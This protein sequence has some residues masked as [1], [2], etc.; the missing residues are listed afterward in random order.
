MSFI[1]KNVK[2]IVCFAVMVILLVALTIG[3][4]ACMN[5]FHLITQFLCGF[6]VDDD[7]SSALAARE[8]NDALAQT[9]EEE[10]AVLLRNENNALPLATNSDG[11]VTEKINVFGASSTDQGFVPQGTGSGTG[12]RNNLVTFMGAL[13]QV[14]IPYNQELAN[15]HA[16][17]GITRAAGGSYVIEAGHTDAGYVQ[18][19]GIWEADQ[20]F[21][22]DAMFAQA[23]AYSE[24]AV[25]VIG[26]LM[27]EG[28]DYSQ[29]QFLA[30]G[31]IINDRTSLTITEREEYLI[32]KCSQTFD[33]VIVILNVANPM[34][35]GFVEQYNVDA[36]L[37][38]GYPGTRGTLGVANLLRGYKTNED[39]TVTKISPSGKLT[40]TYAYKLNSSPAWVNSGREGIGL[41][42]NSG[43]TNKYSDYAEGIYVGYKWY[44]TADA[45]GFWND[46][47]GYD[48][49]VQYPFGFGLSY[50]TFEWTVVYTEFNDG[51]TVDRED[52]LYFEIKVKNTGNYP[53]M[54]V[55]QL[56]YTPPYT[57]GGIE[58]SAVNLG[59]YAKTAV[60]QPGEEEYLFVELNVSDMKSYDCYDENNNGFMGYE[61]EAGEYKISFRTD[62]H[63]LAQT[64]NAGSKNTWTYKVP[65][66]GYQYDQDTWTG[67]DV[68]NQF[69]TFTNS[70]SGASSVVNEPI[71]NNAHSVDGNDESVKITYLTRADFAGTYPVKSNRTLDEKLL[72]DTKVLYDFRRDDNSGTAPTWSSRQ[73][74]WTIEDL[75]G[76]DYDDK[77]WDEAISQLSFEQ[78]KTLI[79]RGGFGTIRIDEIGKPATRDTDG[80]SGFNNSVTGTNDL[81]ASN[82]PCLTVLAS[83]WDWFKA[84]LVGCGIGMEGTGV[85]IQGW[86][87]PGANLHRS[88][89]GGR[90]FEYYSEDAYLSGVTC[91]YHVY[92]AKENGVTAY[93]KHIAVNDCERFRGGAYKWLTEQTLREIYLR[94]FELAVKIGGANGMMASVDRVGSIQASSSY[95]MLTA[96]LRDEWG[97]RGTVITDYYQGR[98]INDIDECVRA[99]CTQMLH[100]DG[101]ME[102]ADNVNSVAGQKAVAKSAKDIL[103]SYTDTMFITATST[104]LDKEALI[105]NGT[106]VFAWWFPVLIAVDVLAVAAMGFWT[107]L[108]L[109]KP[110]VKEV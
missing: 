104:G 47:G 91:A 98:T 85:G 5:N 78:A 50:T 53:G 39:G 43:G 52:I 105:G 107:Y 32:Q 68:K 42:Y 55:V 46:K 38:M 29:R 25:V 18:Y 8:Q 1:K 2:K 35:C 36:L 31:T 56:Y 10:G 57:D 23:E 3:N 9:V 76:L 44:E 63:T 97:F 95:A 17:L 61:L 77:A 26:R 62:A 71:S 110:K 94:P 83:T 103:Y 80:P 20:N 27:G 13:N 96:V 41:S 75:M 88:P 21:Y 86:Y 64:G 73:T 59:A 16:T 101:S 54:D 102:W 22:S 11:T 99:G 106:E 7:S 66:G 49:I 48:A 19:Y 74:R 28:N 51:D 45:E 69:T 15:Q 4:I 100:P 24:T 109:R 89:L 72:S 58:K 81:K 12:S 33:K 93:I 90:N 30:D 108:L 82:Y 79:A 87:G 34:E 37:W 84:Y 14:G 40:D 60:L 65:A 92:G 70:T 6:G 67:N